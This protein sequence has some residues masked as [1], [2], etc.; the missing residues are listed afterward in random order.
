MLRVMRRRAG[1]LL[2]HA[3]G[4]SRAPSLADRAQSYATAASTLAP[5]RGDDANARA[6]VHRRVH[7]VKQ[8]GILDIEIGDTF[9]RVDV[10]STWDE[11]CVV[12]AV[13]DD[14]NE[15]DDDSDDGGG[16]IGDDGDVLAVS[17]DTTRVGDSEGEGDDSGGASPTPA[18]DVDTV[19]VRPA[20]FGPAQGAG[21]LRLRAFVPQLFNVR[22]VA[23][24]GAVTLHSKLEG[25]VDVAVAP[26]PGDVRVDKVRGDVVRLVAAGGSVRIASLLEAGDA[27]VVGARGVDA[28]R[29]MADEL[30][31]A[32]GV[33]GGDAGG[34]GVR[35]EALYARRAA[36]ATDGGDVDVGTAQVAARVGGGGQ[37][38][39]EGE[40]GASSDGGGGSDGAR[41]T[42]AT[43]GG[44]LTCG[45]VDGPLIAFTEGGDIAVH[46]EAAA[47]AVP[48]S[49]LDASPRG[50]GDGDEE[51]HVALG[52]KE[53]G[54][55]AI[56]L[57]A[58][59]TAFEQQRDPGHRAAL[60][61]VR[62]GQGHAVDLRA[63]GGVT[64]ANL[65]DRGLEFRGEAA[66][67][68]TLGRVVPVA[69]ARSE[70]LAAEGSAGARVSGK[71]DPA[72]AAAAAEALA[73]R[74][75][76]AGDDDAA[77]AEDSSGDDVD[78]EEV[79]LMVDAGEGGTV[80]L[81][82]LGW[83]DLVKRRMAALGPDG[84]D[85]DR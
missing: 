66:G 21:P 80:T 46:L 9:A 75:A 7:A 67:G 71:V 15:D 35:V 81:E 30:A 11:Q 77:E 12:E 29:V 54:G 68:R 42:V 65:G 13:A 10:F 59:Q 84:G 62:R 50:Y 58:P 79:G 41:L 6:V 4:N 40:G 20:A 28:V 38:P 85:D 72:G 49:L 17:R 73:S 1:A 16:D 63:G 47:F 43:R 14:C 32:G 36:I 83:V 61:N 60:A 8:G 34:S 57:S 52:G 78:A 23:A 53:T 56:S 51:D 82:I 33:G 64:L 76:G 55:G 2:R 48:G 39:P 3:R 19:T 25:D 22:V 37:R 31:L 74:G 5:D 26:G 27:A 45:G 69:A 70:G 24:R 44:A 18:R